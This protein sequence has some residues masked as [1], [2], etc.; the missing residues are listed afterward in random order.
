MRVLTPERGCSN[1]FNYFSLL[2]HWHFSMN[3]HLIWR[4]SN[5]IQYKE[6]CVVIISF[7]SDVTTIYMQYKTAKMFSLSL[8]LCHASNLY[9]GC[10]QPEPLLSFFTHKLKAPLPGASNCF[11][12]TPDSIF[13]LAHFDLSFCLDLFESCFCQLDFLMLS[14]DSGST[15]P[16][17]SLLPLTSSKLP[18][19]MLN[20]AKHFPTPW[21]DSSR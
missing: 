8:L 19:K 3:V 15:E 9:H 21:R 11:N 7:I 10:N 5:R 13:H 18:V 14:P 12:L 17:M 1:C 2:P 6:C 4:I 20:K 16:L